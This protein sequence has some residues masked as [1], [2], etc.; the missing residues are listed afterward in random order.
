MD[1][2]IIVISNEI[3]KIVKDIKISE[4]NY[5]APCAKDKHYMQSLLMTLRIRFMGQ[6]RYEEFLANM[7]KMAFDPDYNKNGEGHGLSYVINFS[8]SLK[9]MQD[10]FKSEFIDNNIGLLIF[11]YEILSEKFVY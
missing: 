2:N 10:Q 3:Y 11:K 8:C 4:K 5:P 6:F 7:V 1:Q 9:E